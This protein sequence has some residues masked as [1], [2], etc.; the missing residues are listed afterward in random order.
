MSPYEVVGDR[1]LHQ[2]DQQLLERILRIITENVGNS[3][4]T[5]NM[6]ADEL[7]MGYRTLY[8]R[9]QD[10]SDKTLAI[11]IRDIRMEQARQLLTQTKLTIEQIALQVGYVN[12]GSF[13]KHFT[14]HFGCTPRQFQADFTAE[15]VSSTAG[16]VRHEDKTPASPSEP[17]GESHVKD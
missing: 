14:A 13:Y 10:I 8:R 2:E 5:P 7:C 15:A 6:V 17:I 11:I 9:L 16:N 4:L 12:R 1:V 3:E